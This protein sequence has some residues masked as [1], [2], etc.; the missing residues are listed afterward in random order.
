MNKI[1]FTILF[2]IQII[3]ADECFCD[4]VSSDASDYQSYECNIEEADISLCSITTKQKYVHSF[5]SEIHE[6]IIKTKEIQ[7]DC[8]ENTKINKLVT[9]VDETEIKLK[10]EGLY[11]IETFES[12]YSTMIS[13]Q[14]TVYISQVDC[15][16]LSLDLSSGS[17]VKYSGN[18]LDLV[19]IQGTLECMNEI[20]ITELIMQSN[21]YVSLKES[22]TISK[23][24]LDSSEFIIVA[25]KLGSI[26]ELSPNQMILKSD[27][28]FDVTLIKSLKHQF[29]EI[30]LSSRM[31]DFEIVRCCADNEIHLKRKS[32]EIKCHSIT[33]D[34]EKELEPKNCFEI[35]QQSTESI[36]IYISLQPNYDI[37]KIKGKKI[38]KLIIPENI[39]TTLDGGDIQ[40]EEVIIQKHAKLV[41]K[42][43]SI[44]AESVDLENVQTNR[45]NVISK[46]SMNN[47][48]LTG[49]V[50]ITNSE[51]FIKGP[52]TFENVQVIFSNFDIFHFDSGSV[53]ASNSS[54]IFSSGMFR[55]N[56]N[57]Q[58]NGWLFIESKIDFDGGIDIEYDNGH[59]DKC[60]KIMTFQKSQ[61]SMSM[62]TRGK[63][64]STLVLD[65]SKTGMYTC[66]DYNFKEIYTLENCKVKG[67]ELTIPAET[68]CH[69][70]ALYCN[71]I[72]SGKTLHISE[73]IGGIEGNDL[74]I[75]GY[76]IIIDTLKCQGECHLYGEMEIHSMNQLSGHLYI[77]GIITIQSYTKQEIRT[78]LTVVELGNL[79]IK[80]EIISNSNIYVKNKASL[81]LTIS[82]L[83]NCQLELE[84]TSL[85]VVYDS[86]L[87]LQNTN[88]TF[89]G[90]IHNAFA[91]NHHSTISFS[92]ESIIFLNKQLSE[93]EEGYVVYA[94]KGG[95]INIPLVFVKDEEG[96]YKY[97]DVKIKCQNYIVVNPRSDD[98]MCPKQPFNMKG[99]HV[100][101][102][103]KKWNKRNQFS[104]I[105]MFSILVTFGLIVML[106]FFVSFV[107]STKKHL[108]KSQ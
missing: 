49:F 82:M 46:V 1:I 63:T 70:E 108:L 54:L 14:S 45:L 33:C 5:P 77:H 104:L 61:L 83:E 43:E 89:N 92:S 21:G 95:I 76:G 13:T 94:P 29:P 18:K 24:V 85:A 3:S 97:Y 62:T 23:F 107:S 98:V 73:D 26:K 59:D 42:F 58:F 9:I 11:T 96:Q 64:R 48:R 36:P 93:S 56:Y 60:L 34:L 20:E 19:S 102:I 15:D 53:I 68:N 31:S 78:S 103:P 91:L 22:Y 105:V 17:V 71:Y 57:E 44:I 10:G 12:D 16:F 52:V 27:K 84:E 55:G 38:V 101:L 87:I 79:I 72:Y 28:Q 86:N 106:Y 81:E 99:L 4:L 35:V 32:A 88:I 39:D 50:D 6:F 41:G 8:L 90:I 75:E 66:Y 69:C 7:I 65:T 2:L 47:V 40:C 67:D 51:I 30:K 100:V 80:T 25:E 74:S 37:R